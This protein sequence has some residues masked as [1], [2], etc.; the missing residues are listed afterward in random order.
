VHRQNSQVELPLPDPVALAHSERLRERILQA[1]DSADGALAFSQFMEMALYEPGLGYY[2]AGTAKFGP[3]GDFV[4]AGELGD[5]LARAVVTTLAP[6]L[7]ALPQPAVVEL[8]A[9]TGALAAAILQQLDA[10]GLEHVRYRILEPSPDLQ[11]RQR[12]LLAAHGSRVDWIETLR[13]DSVCG[14]IIANEVADAL[15]VERVVLGS[16]GWQQLAV[17]RSAREFRWCVQ[18]LPRDLAQALGAI[19]AELA[20][21]LREGYVSELRPLLGPWVRTLGA[22]LSAGDVLV[23]DYGMS[24]REYYHPQRDGGTLMCHYRHRAHADPFVYPGLQ[25]ITAWVDFSACARAAQAAGLRT[26]GFTTQGAWIAAAVLSDR[27]LPGELDSH[28]AAQL[29]TLLLPGEMGE[30]FKV[31]LLRR[32]ADALPAPPLPGRDLRARL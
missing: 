9:G 24:R 1:I 22:A 32:D 4:T 27:A 31:L 17:A 12:A 19:S 29:K 23:I 8:G 21:P 10:C 16:A 26:A 11:S 6:R 25:D 28:G 15:P 5:F 20:E 13:P 3:A 7:A 14:A 30:R 2:S 18:S